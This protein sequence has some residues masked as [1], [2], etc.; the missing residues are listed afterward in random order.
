MTFYRP[1]CATRFLCWAKK[2]ADAGAEAGDSTVF[3]WEFAASKRAGIDRV[4]LLKRNGE[5]MSIRD[6]EPK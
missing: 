3:G 2:E 1:E 4:S 5:G 6:D